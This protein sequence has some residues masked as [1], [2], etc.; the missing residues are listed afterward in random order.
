MVLRSV[1]QV[2]APEL[3]WDLAR[4]QRSPTGTDNS[5]AV[6][7]QLSPTA[8]LPAVW[9]LD[10]P[11]IPGPKIFRIAFS[12]DSAIQWTLY[13]AAANP[14]IAALTPYKLGNTINAATI[15]PKGAVIAAPAVVALLD[16]GYAAAN[17]YTVILQPGWLQ[18]AGN[19][20]VILATTAVAANCFASFWW[21]EY[22]T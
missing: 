6:A 20:S 15:T 12:T 17:S 3:M 22:L 4:L 5:Y 13:V 2:G 1:E 9:C 10:F 8:L 11:A 7:A 16:G 21:A 18:A 14:A 19:K